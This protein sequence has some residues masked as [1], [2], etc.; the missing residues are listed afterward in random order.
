MQV[1]NQAP[2]LA[3]SVIDLTDLKDADLTAEIERFGT[4]EAGLAFDLSSDPLLR[5]KLLLLGEEDSVL[6]ITMHHIV[7]DGWSMEVLVRDL[8]AFYEQFTTGTPAQLPELPIQYADYS[9]WQREW[10]ESETMEKQLSYWRRQLHGIPSL[11][12]LPKDRP[13]PPVQSYRG[14]LRSLVVPATLAQQ[15]NEF[16]RKEGVTL[17]TT[18]LA[19]LQT[20]LW[21]YTGQ[22]DVVVGTPVANRN[23]PEIEGL[24]G[25][26]VN[27]LVMRSDVSGNPTFRELLG[28]VR[29]VVLNALANQD[30][31]FEKLVDDLQP[32]RSL[33]RTPLFQINFTLQTAR[34]GFALN[35]IEIER[36]AFERTTSKFDLILTV[37]E[38]PE[39]LGDNS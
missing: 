5:V 33:S 9:V 2:G 38:R 37:L 17:F 25:F 4:A 10:L 23:R 3:F 35:G 30:L 31:P 1:I 15:L 6:F 13:R 32:E 29:E 19:A 28:R 12:E 36:I 34:Q 21:R 24:I 20:L 16:S 14:R 39:H 27:T 18:L 7:S 8:A 22:E 26:F 11:F